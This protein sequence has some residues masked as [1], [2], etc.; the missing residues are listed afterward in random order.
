MD[1]PSSTR[2]RVPRL[3]FVLFGLSISVFIWGLQYKLSLY[4]PPLCASHQIAKAK[5]LSENER[6]SAAASTLISGLHFRGAVP[7]AWILFTGLTIWASVLCEVSNPLGS[8]LA[9]E[10]KRPWLVS[11]WTKLNAFFF[12]PPPTPILL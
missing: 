4:N 3:T 5:L 2:P 8:T 12:R 10:R 7:Q 9:L 1:L 11:T 6:A